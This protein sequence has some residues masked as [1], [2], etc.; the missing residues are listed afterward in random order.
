MLPQ[1]VPEQ[2]VCACPQEDMY[3]FVT[4]ADDQTTKGKGTSVVEA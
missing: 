4:Y 3:S 2:A 1:R